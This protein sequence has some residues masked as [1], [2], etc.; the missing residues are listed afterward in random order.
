MVSEVNDG[1]TLAKQHV[2]ERRPARR[3]LHAAPH[4][5]YAM[6]FWKNECMGANSN[7]GQSI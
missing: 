1:N 4:H 6:L 5:Q 3:L 2:A 7:H